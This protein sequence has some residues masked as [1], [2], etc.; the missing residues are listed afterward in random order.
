MSKTKTREQRQ[1]KREQSKSLQLTSTVDVL[2]FAPKLK[3]FI[4]KSNLSAVLKKGQAPYVFVDGWKFA[5]MSFGLTCVP[6]EPVLL[7]QISPVTVYK[8]EWKTNPT[9]QKS[10]SEKIDTGKTVPELR[11]KCKASVKRVLTDEVVS[12][13]FGICSNREDGKEGFDEYAVYSMAQTRAIAKAYRNLLGFL[14]KAAGFSDTPAEE[15][16]GSKDTIPVINYETVQQSLARI[17]RKEELHQ[18]FEGL[19]ESMK[20]DKKVLE[21]FG[22]RK[23]AISLKTSQTQKA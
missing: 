8:V 9:T 12:F 4:E 14:M 1:A 11:Y 20:T 23:A 15:M 13:G 2:G 5:G 21:M 3:D 10:Y 19:D 6:D 22:K 7:E 16:E 17:E 18:Y